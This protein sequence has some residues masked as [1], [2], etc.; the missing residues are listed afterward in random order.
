[1]LLLYL[2]S[3]QLFY[4]LDRKNKRLRFPLLFKCIINT[5]IIFFGYGKVTIP[6]PNSHKVLAILE[7]FLHC[8]QIKC[9]Y[10][11]MQIVPI[12]GASKIV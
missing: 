4:H 7:Y 6:T 9:G 8:V 3:N 10:L 12:Q 11:N 2:Q 1:M 5:N